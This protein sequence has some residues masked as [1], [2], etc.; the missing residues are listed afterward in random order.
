MSDMPTPAILDKNKTPKGDSIEFDVAD[1]SGED[2]T[3]VDGLDMTYIVHRTPDGKET[4]MPMSEWPAY[5][6]KNNL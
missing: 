1:T 2:E 4:R 5:A 6:R 3:Y